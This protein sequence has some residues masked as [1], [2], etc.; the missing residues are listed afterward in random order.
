MDE[1]EKQEIDCRKAQENLQ[2]MIDGGYHKEIAKLA[3]VMFDAY[4]EQGFNAE[5][6]LKLTISLL[7]S[8]IPKG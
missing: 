6:A 8:T 4:I 5:Q 3:K 2:H 7:I 1:K